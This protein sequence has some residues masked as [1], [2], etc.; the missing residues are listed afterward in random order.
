MLGVSG[1]GD[2]FAALNL[3][4]ESNLRV[5]SVQPILPPLGSGGI[6]RSG[7]LWRRGHLCGGLAALVLADFLVKATVVAGCVGWV[8]HVGLGGEVLDGR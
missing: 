7:L 4:P 5:E 3:G 1:C 2:M 8:S 6:C